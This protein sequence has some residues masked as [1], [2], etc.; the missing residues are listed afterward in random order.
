VDKV[1]PST[2]SH[3]DIARRM[4]ELLSAFIAEA[5]PEPGPYYQPLTTDEVSNSSPATLAKAL[6]FL[7]YLMRPVP[8]EASVLD[9]GSGYG[10]NCILLGLLG[11]RKVVGV[12]MVDP[13]YRNSRLLLDFARSR[14][15]YDLSGVTI[16]QGDIQELPFPGASFDCVLCVEVISHVASQDALLR[17]ANRLLSARR[18][19]IVSDGCNISDPRAHNRFLKAWARVRREEMDK[20]LLFLAERCPDLDPSA[21]ERIALQTELLGRDALEA[22]LSSIASGDELPDR[23]WRKG[24]APV[25]FETGL[26]AENGIRLSDLERRL[27]QHGF[28]PRVRISY[29][30]CRGPA[31]HAAETCLNLLPRWLRYRTRPVFRCWAR[32]AEACN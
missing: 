1:D 3:I 12:E 5:A 19:L 24:T 15:P 2:G 29:G 16:Q 6:R 26:W 31:Y 28:S 25:Y 9:M 18:L 7:S 30:G 27:V 13:L 21:R 17:E 20:R 22:L 8:R 14:L 4:A 32:K 10:L 23:R 11:F